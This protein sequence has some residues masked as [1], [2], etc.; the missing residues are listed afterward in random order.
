MITKNV[1]R[2][3]IKYKGYECCLGYTNVKDDL[4]EYKC[5]C[6]EAILE[7]ELAKT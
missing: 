1:K 6:C 4:L 3:G 2:C 7:K 5:L